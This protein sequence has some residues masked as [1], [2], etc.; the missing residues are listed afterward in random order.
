MTVVTE[1]TCVRTLS[2]S[3]TTHKQALERA[4]CIEWAHRQLHF[5]PTDKVGEISLGL[6][7]LDSDDPLFK[8]IAHELEQALNVSAHTIRIHH[9]S[10]SQAIARHR[11][12][13]YPNS[14]TVIIR[15][16]DAPNQES[17]FI[18][19]DELVAERAGHGYLM[20]EHTPHEVIKG[21]HERYTIAAWVHRK[22]LDNCL[23]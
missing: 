20:P 14:D 1:Q 11:D 2:L 4:T 8:A 22:S 21:K 16:N 15:L 10:A 6:K 7:A 9:V 18:I 19:N 13:A 12:D 17:R 5:A 23:L 3:K